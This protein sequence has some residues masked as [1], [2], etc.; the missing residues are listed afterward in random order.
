MYASEELDCKLQFTLNYEPQDWMSQYIEEY[1]NIG[2][3][4]PCY[5]AILHVAVFSPAKKE[6]RRQCID[7]SRLSV[8]NDH[9]NPLTIEQVTF[10]TSDRSLNN[11]IQQ[12]TDF[13]PKSLNLQRDML[14][15][16]P[17]TTRVEAK[18]I[19]RPTFL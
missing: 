2:A 13:A 10:F 19:I 9:R 5:G 4:L 17:P 1:D 8:H 7:F 12:A 11:S 16:F 14:I 15:T 6:V 3:Y 18:F